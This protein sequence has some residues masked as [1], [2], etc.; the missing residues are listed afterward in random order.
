MYLLN[1]K[2]RGIVSTI[3]SI[4]NKTIKSLDKESDDFN[5]S[6]IINNNN[7]AF[8]ILN[9]MYKNKQLVLSK[10]DNLQ[11]APSLI[12][13]TFNSVLSLLDYNSLTDNM[14]KLD[15]SVASSDT[16]NTITKKL[17][18]EV[19][20]F[21]YNT[22]KRVKRY[23]HKVDAYIKSGSSEISLND[24]FK[25]KVIKVS[26]MYNMM[27]DKN[28][29]ETYL[30][31]DKSQYS[32]DLSSLS[33][34]NELKDI[35]LSIFR[36]DELKHLPDTDY[37]NRTFSMFT[38]I[39]SNIGIHNFVDNLKLEDINA[40][41][42]ITLMVNELYTSS[43]TEEIALV[44]NLLVNKLTYLYGNYQNNLKNNNLV[45]SY[46]KNAE[47]DYTITMLDELY[48]SY[49]EDDGKF[50]AITGFVIKHMYDNKIDHIDANI[51]T[52]GLVSKIQIEKENYINASKA[53]LNSRILESKN[54]EH[55]N[56]VNY[57]IF[58]LD[59]VTDNKTDFRR[60]VEAFVKTLS[61]GELIDTSDTALKVFRKVVMKG[62]NFDAFMEGFEEADM[63]LKDADEKTL[64]TYAAY[65]LIL[66]YFYIQTTLVIDNK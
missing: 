60:E 8:T 11:T 33:L 12:I 19:S 40:L 5:S 50:R 41:I 10:R 26:D 2:N 51:N 13:P 17:N 20:A 25:L 45:I 36:E 31:N 30:V 16:I 22:L 15:M 52:L 29:L 1:N 7:L 54:R 28:I 46:V 6:Y 18:N 39:T 4:A 35:E 43:P 59:V 65:K 24:M 48:K 57:Y 64:G 3:V 42:F 63:I 9:T 53:F 49:M 34:N 37:V 32:F 38:G 58:A 44:K 21:K 62:T 27:L 66:K 47:D 56:M 55:G 23:G 61:I 14:L